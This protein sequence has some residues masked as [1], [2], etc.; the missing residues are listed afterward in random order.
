MIDDVKYTSGVSVPTSVDKDDYSLRNSV[1]EIALSWK[2]EN[3][4]A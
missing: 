2:S 3:V 4:I 1:E